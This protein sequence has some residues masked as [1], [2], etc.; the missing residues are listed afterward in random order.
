MLTQ[1]MNSFSIISPKLEVKHFPCQL[2]S[3]CGWHLPGWPHIALGGLGVHNIIVPPTPSLSSHS[4]VLHVLF[5]GGQQATKV[6]HKLPSRGG[7]YLCM[8][9]RAREKPSKRHSVRDKE[10]QHCVWTPKPEDSKGEA[11]TAGTTVQYSVMGKDPRIDFH[12][13]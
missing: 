13:L 11:H 1:L 12:P 8:F 3:P 4:S 7:K 6:E 10:R 2:L 5:R 9:K